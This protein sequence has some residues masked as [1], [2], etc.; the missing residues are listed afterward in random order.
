V[1]VT[2]IAEF[3]SEA[4]IFVWAPCKAGKKDECIRAGLGQPNLGA[5]SRVI[6]KYGS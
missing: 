5:T 2:N 6:R 3:S 4:D 1:S